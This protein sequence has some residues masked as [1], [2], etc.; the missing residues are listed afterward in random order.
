M[1]NIGVIF[2]GESCEHDISII[3]GVQL[4]ANMDEYLYNII[5]IY[6]DKNGT[7]LTG[8]NLKDIDNFPKNLGKL[9]EVALVSNDSN[10]Y[11]KK[12]NKLK[13]YKKLDMVF[14][15]LHGQ[16]G[17]DGSVAGVLELCKI[18]YSSSSMLSSSV[19]MDKVVFKYICKGMN[20][21]CVNGF[22][23]IKHDFDENKEDVLS[24]IND[25]GLPIIIKPSRQ[26]S[27]IGIKVC[28]NIEDLEKDLL[29][30]FQYDNRL[31][32]EEYLNVKKE[33]NIAIFRNKNDLCF[34]KTEE[35]V[36]SNDILGFDEKYRKNSGGF[37]TIKRITPANISRE[38]ECDIMN[39]ASRLYSIL[40]MFG[41]VR[42]D[43]LIDKD[44]KVY[45]NEV[46]S[47]PGSMANYLYDKQ[48]EYRKLIDLLVISSMIRKDN[49]DLLIKKF[50]SG[51]LSQGFDGFKK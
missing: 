27:S 33:V 21:N 20:I 38:Q 23:V 30:C 15:C 6:I 31:L 34:S 25:F 17:E 16:R 10:L 49:D 24:K 2:G 42:F 19:A 5:P 40:D 41:V 18:P 45:V 50:D 12:K 3:T 7:W 39:I 32:I 26:G 1:M 46:N 51:V 48:F 28:K 44:D 9:T 13:L 11:I 4:I 35:P 43:F 22:E 36:Y 37:Q 47:I 8:K 29:D 14:V